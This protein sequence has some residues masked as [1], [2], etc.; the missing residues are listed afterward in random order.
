MAFTVYRAGVKHGLP[1]ASYHPSIRCTNQIELAG[2][3][4]V[5]ALP[6]GI[7][8]I[9]NIIVASAGVTV[10]VKDGEGTLVIPHVGD[11]DTAS[12]SIWFVHR[13]DG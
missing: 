2:T 8:W 13:M 7:F 12:N 9:E 10:A 5:V 1:Q 11:F 4:P 6:N 3:D